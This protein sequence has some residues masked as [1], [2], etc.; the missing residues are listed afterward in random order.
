MLPQT[1]SLLQ[2]DKYHISGDIVY[3][4]DRVRV[5]NHYDTFGIFDRW[6]D[7]HP[8]AKKLHGIYHQGTRF[9][10]K[11]ELHINGHRPLLLSS[12]IKEDNQMLSVD[13]SNPVF[14]DCNIEEHT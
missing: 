12:S 11:M 7:I 14:R 2:E 8:H 6:G 9:I 1:Q 13:L 4:D 3:V 10:N 5:L